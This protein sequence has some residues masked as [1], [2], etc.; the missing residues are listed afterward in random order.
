[1]TGNLGLNKP[2]S[3]AKF[4]KDHI[5]SPMKAFQ[6]CMCG[7]CCYGEGGI[8]V[9]KDEIRKIAHYLGITQKALLSRFCEEKYGRISVK[10]GPDKFCIF[11]DKITHCLIHPVKPKPC[12]LWPFY[13]AI[14]SDRENWEM[15]KDACPGINKDCTF[16]EFISQAH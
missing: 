9:E 13:P 1:M 2:S 16:E 12:S 14:V 15:A 5:I 3:P 10:T 4:M 11:F 7:E 8:F 6:C